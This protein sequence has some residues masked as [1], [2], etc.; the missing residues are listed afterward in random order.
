MIL[1]LTI[2]HYPEASCLAAF[3][4]LLFCAVVYQKLSWKSLLEHCTRESDDWDQAWEEFQRRY[5]KLILYFLRQEL[6]R[7]CGP[8][9]E[10]LKEAC[11]DLRQDVY[12]KLLADRGRALSEFR[13]TKEETFAVFLN[14]ICIRTVLNYLK[15][16]QL[17]PVSLSEHFS[18]SEEA[19][20]ASEQMS[21]PDA[22]EEAESH[23][24]RDHLMAHLQE[25][26]NSR[27]PERDLLIFR[28]FYLEGYSAEE[29]ESRFDFNI[30]KE[31]ITTLTTRMKQKLKKSLETD[32]F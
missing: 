13:G 28:L 12:I 23:F 15:A 2:A 11:K 30:S 8:L 10:T 16:R 1:S 20:A 22:P 6:R 27:N 7:R 21:A 9:N 14:V 19:A 26:H 5:G 18:D 25:I 24:A 4:L 31:G 3:L 32:F 29:I 17:R